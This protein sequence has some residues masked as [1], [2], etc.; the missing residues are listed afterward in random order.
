M[1]ELE[2]YQ[3]AF[4]EIATIIG[5][6]DRSLPYDQN[7]GHYDT[8]EKSDVKYII[9]ENLSSDKGFEAEHH[10]GMKVMEIVLEG[11]EIVSVSGSVFRMESGRFLIYSGSDDVKKHPH[12]DKCLRINYSGDPSLTED[13]IRI[14]AEK[15]REY[16]V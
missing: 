16:S 13:G 4:P 3:G 5:V 10:P 14:I 7:P 1:D 2:S 8:P 6:M 15:Y 9:D 11:D 12:Y